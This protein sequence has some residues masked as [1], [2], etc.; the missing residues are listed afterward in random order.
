MSQRRSCFLGEWK[1][2]VLQF[3][4]LF[5]F[6]ILSHLGHESPGPESAVGGIYG[7]G[8]GGGASRKLV[9]PYVIRSA[10]HG[11]KGMQGHVH[12]CTGERGAAWAHREG[13]H[14]PFIRV[15]QVEGVAV[16]PQ[17]G[18]S[19]VFWAWQGRG[20]TGWGWCHA[21]TSGCSHVGV[22][23]AGDLGVWGVTL[24]SLAERLDSFS[25]RPGVG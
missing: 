21:P 8:G 6:I 3:T 1:S 17:T 10:I 13:Q 16:Q 25:W 15:L 19:L 23:S 18:S 24:L 5:H 9:A 12:T 7:P 11:A 4:L 14:C 20:Y 2:L 22:L